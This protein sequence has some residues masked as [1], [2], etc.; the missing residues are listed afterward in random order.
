MYSK[1]N[2]S[3]EKCIDQ[4]EFGFSK[5]KKNNVEADNRKSGLKFLGVF[6]KFFNSD[7]SVSKIKIPEVEK[8]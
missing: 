4:K 1:S 7:W 6:N 3:V 5:S 8:I 2:K